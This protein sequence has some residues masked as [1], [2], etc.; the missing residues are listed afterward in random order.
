[1]VSVWKLG[2]EKM[3]DVYREAKL[4]SLAFKP[5]GEGQVGLVQLTAA[6]NG[7]R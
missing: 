1:M 7:A 6:Q 5:D 2:Q 3:L 4:S